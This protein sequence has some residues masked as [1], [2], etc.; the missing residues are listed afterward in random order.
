[1]MLLAGPLD[2]GLL[3]YLGRSFLAGVAPS[4]APPVA[5]VT[6]M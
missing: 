5:S 1:M 2:R 3:P 4:L 6:G